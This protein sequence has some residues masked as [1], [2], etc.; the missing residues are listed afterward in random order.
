MPWNGMPS[1]APR[2]MERLLT[3]QAQ[4][5][6]NLCPVSCF[7]RLVND[8]G[9]AKQDDGEEV[10]SLKKMP[11]VIYNKARSPR[12]VPRSLVETRM[13]P[14]YIQPCERC[15]AEEAAAVI[16]LGC[17]DCI[18]EAA[19]NHWTT[20][21]TEYW[22]QYP[23]DPREAVITG[24]RD[25]VLTSFETLVFPCVPPR[26][27]ADVV[28]WDAPLP[29][30]DEISKGYLAWRKIWHR[31]V[32]KS[33]PAAQTCEK[34]A[35]VEPLIKPL[36]EGADGPGFQMWGSI[37]NDYVL[38]CRGELDKEALEYTYELELPGIE[39]ML[40]NL[41]DWKNECEWLNDYAGMRRHLT[42]ATCRIVWQAARRAAVS[43]EMLA[44][45]E[46]SAT[47]DDSLPV[48]QMLEVERYTVRQNFMDLRA[49]LLVS[50]SE[51]SSGVA[52]RWD[53]FV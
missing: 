29:G 43:L 3:P 52:L 38:Y 4:S 30:F 34:M 5:L 9:L 2:S 26:W 48:H 13:R 46:K 22:G 8:T 51:L 35:L 44:R 41:D 37:Q 11:N 17:E 33:S 7:L 18:A 53:G 49:K 25:H 31:H 14:W 21:S 45:S 10:G 6:A 32:F 50:T 36:L 47:S 24:Y 28:F 27:L 20:E 39:F 15:A 19:L 40:T 16:D 1:M 12:A 42:S 23:V